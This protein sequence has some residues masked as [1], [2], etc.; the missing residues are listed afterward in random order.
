MTAT[1]LGNSYE[2][3][4]P[5]GS[6]TSQ[7]D[8]S[9]LF[10]AG[11]RETANS[12]IDLFILNTNKINMIIAPL[13]TIDNELS[14]LCLLG[15]VSAIESYIRALIRSIIQ[16]DR[17]SRTAS[18]EKEIKFSAAM[19][20]DKKLLAEA[21]MD[22]FSFTKFSNIQETFKNLLD[23]NIA[24]H[25]LLSKDFDNVCQLRHCSV[26]R[27]GKL[28]AKNAVSL[29]LEKHSRLIEKPMEINL[30]QL[31]HIFENLRIFVRALNNAA[32]KAVMSRTFP[33]GK[34]KDCKVKPE[35]IWK[36]R[37]SD[38]KEIYGQYYSVFRS[39]F[40]VVKT[41]QAKKMYDL[42]ISAKEQEINNPTT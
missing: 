4:S 22:D 35:N 39:R 18:G 19:H 30:A 33:V 16:V 36:K 9:V 1:T 29:G 12:P 41:P 40:D 20:H 10:K 6:F 42:F 11:F 34:Q 27:F 24:I 31:N 15:Y 13:S 3:I 17:F 21:L 8:T 14:S 26:H 38:D 28:G 32:Y 25:E 7:I 2:D 23:L 37:Y 5:A